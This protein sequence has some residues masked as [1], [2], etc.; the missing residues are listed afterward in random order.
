VKGDF[1]PNTRT[2]TRIYK[3]TDNF[4]LPNITTVTMRRVRPEQ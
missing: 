3:R 4:T 1:T 2:G